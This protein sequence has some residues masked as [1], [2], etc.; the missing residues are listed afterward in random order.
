MT[1]IYSKHLVGGLYAPGTHLS[2]YSV[3]ALSTVVIRDIYAVSQAAGTDV[4]EL[5][6]HSDG[7]V[8]FRATST[9][10]GSA[11]LRT[12]RPVVAAGD[13]LD[14]TVSAGG[15]WKLS[16]DGYLLQ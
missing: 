4:I 9:A 12:G 13:T 6:R 15:S 7:S 1:A 8:I 14:L 3:P 16:L 11:F 10:A 2:V 5:T